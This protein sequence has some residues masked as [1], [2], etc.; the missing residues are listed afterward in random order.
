MSKQGKT[1][2]TQDTNRDA[3]WGEVMVAADVLVDQFLSC[4][5]KLR[6]LDK[7]SPKYNYVACSRVVWVCFGKPFIVLLRF[8]VPCK[9]N[10]LQK[11]YE[12]RG[13]LLDNIYRLELLRVGWENLADQ[14]SI[15]VKD[16]F[17]KS[18]YAEERKKYQAITESRVSCFTEV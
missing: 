14:G 3:N 4:E 15:N 8:F 11:I 12:I 16:L 6:L 5:N 13:M 17:Y 18:D 9:L 1:S 2:G 7:T 10:H